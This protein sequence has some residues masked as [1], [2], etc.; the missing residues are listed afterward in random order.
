MRVST[1]S[2][3]LSALGKRVLDTRFGLSWLLGRSRRRLLGVRGTSDG[4]SYESSVHRVFGGVHS[5]SVLAPIALIL[6]ALPAFGQVPVNVGPE[7][8]TQ[9]LDQT[10]HPLSGGIV[11]TYQAGT[12]IPL[13]TYQDSLGTV[14]NSNPIVL[15][16]DGRANI[17][18]QSAAYKVVLAGGGTCASPS[19]LQWTVDGFSVGVF[20]AGNNTWTGTNVFNNTT[21]FNGAVNMNAGGSMNGTFSGNPNFSGSPTFSG[22]IVAS[23]FQS[24]VA[25]GTPP[26]IVAS[27]TKVA[28]LNV[29]ALDDCI[30]SGSPSA[31]MFLQAT[32][33]TACQW[34]AASSF[35]SVAYSTQS[36]SVNANISPV[37]MATVGGSDATYRFSFYVELSVIGSGCAGGSGAAAN[38]V[39]NL[40]YQDP[41]A[42]STTTSA[43]QVGL[44]AAGD[45]GTVGQTFQY[46]PLVT[47]MPLLPIRAKTGTAI[48]YSTTYTT[49]SGCSPK[50]KYIVFPILEQ[51]TSN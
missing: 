3:I 13:A 45:N 11:C 16:S 30:V 32:S 50:P 36:S 2:S 19:N 33:S 5:L 17:W 27:T 42:V 37:T 31:G 4:C 35:P 29:A 12:A 43:S 21:T 7:P 14:L 28:N 23:Q 39:V 44:T 6:I 10:G 8:K 15:S 1:F 49:S 22:T 41:L 38:V 9:F 26:L 48:Q 25:T 20:L 24:T 47:F 51:L 18:Y 40:I 46:D 34:T